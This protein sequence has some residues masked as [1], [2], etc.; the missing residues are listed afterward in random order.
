MG[1]SKRPGDSSRALLLQTAA[2]STTW[3]WTR[4]AG[5][6]SVARGGGT[7]RHLVRFDDPTREWHRFGFHARGGRLS[8]TLG[9]RQSDIWNLE[10]ILRR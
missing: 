8:F 6:W 10:V 9:D 3:P 7:P 1:Q 2:R 4:R 5:I